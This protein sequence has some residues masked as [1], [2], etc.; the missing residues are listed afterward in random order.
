MKELI[1]SVSG[2]IYIITCIVI[3]ILLAMHVVKANNSRYFKISRNLCAVAC[4]SAL[5]ACF[6]LKSI[7]LGVLIY[8]ILAVPIWLFN[9]IFNHKNMLNTKESERREAEFLKTQPIDVEYKE[10]N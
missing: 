1:Y 4:I 6:S 8:P 10:L 5:I 3:F 7:S 2:I 9:T